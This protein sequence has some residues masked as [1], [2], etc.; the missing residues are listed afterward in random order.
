MERGLT[1]TKVYR[2]Y[3]RRFYNRPTQ[4]IDVYAVSGKQAIY[5]FRR[6]YGYAFAH[7]CVAYGVDR[8]YMSDDDEELGTIKGVQNGLQEN[9]ADIDNVGYYVRR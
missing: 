1:M 9:T 5:F 7:D 2:L 6:T 4:Y 8:Y 3:Y